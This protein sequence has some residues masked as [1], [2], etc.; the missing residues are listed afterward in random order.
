VKDQLKQTLQQKLDGRE[1]LPAALADVLGSLRQ[2][3]YEL[4]FSPRDYNVALQ[5]ASL[6]DA[7]KSQ[8][9]TVI[10]E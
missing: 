10:P 4:G 9:E 5:Q 8:A 2:A 7:A 3:A 1:P 6:I